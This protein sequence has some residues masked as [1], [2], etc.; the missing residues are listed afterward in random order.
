MPAR[1]PWLTNSVYPTSHFNPGATDS[2]L[3]AGPVKGK[4]LVRDTDVKVVPNLMVSNPVV[5]KIGSDTV[6]FA[7]GTLGIR[8]ILATEKDF[9]SVS[10][11]PYPGYEQKAQMADDQAVAA[12]LAE[13]D[14]GWRAK[15]EAKLLAAVAGFERLGVTREDGINGVYN[16]FDRDGFHYCVYGGTKVIK[17]TDDNATRGPVRLIKSVDVAAAM[18]PDEAKAVSRIIGLNMTYDGF[19]AAA[20]PGALVVFDRDLNVKSYVAFPGEAVV[21]SIVIDERNGIYVVTS[22]RMVKIMWNG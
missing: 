6:L 17:T 3:H 9:E 5:K 14:A 8:K 2:V 18:P 15:D 7:S 22:R 1:N 20:A 10:F 16:L 4:R 19:I 13:F 11:L 12:L 21:N